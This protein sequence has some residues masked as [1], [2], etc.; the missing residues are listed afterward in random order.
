MRDKAAEHSVDETEHDKSRGDSDHHIHISP[1]NDLVLLPSYTEATSGQPEQP[2]QQSSA[3][4][5]PASNLISIHKIN[6][7]IR[8]TWVVDTDLKVPKTLLSPPSSTGERHHLSLTSFNGAI[9]ADV[10]LL[11][12]K[13]DRAS[14]LLDTKNGGISL[15]IISSKSEQPFKAVLKTCNGGIHV[16]LP[17][18]FIGPIKHH[19]SNGSYKFSSEMQERLRAISS[20]CSFLG[21]WE[22]SGFVD[23][24]QWK[25]YELDASTLNG[26]VKFSYYYDEGP[27][28]LPQSTAGRFLWFTRK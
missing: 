27:S 2:G 18:S 16:Q 28:S 15:N 11:S 21:S 22:D 8:G 3:L 26:S 9:T 14:I 13:S 25:G 6:G 17:R 19:T 10:A 23:Y 20:D 24:E 5:P 7:C 1:S 12:E 4:L